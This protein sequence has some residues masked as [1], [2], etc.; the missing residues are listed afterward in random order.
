MY[1]FY[2]FRLGTGFSF[3]AGQGS[4]V[5]ALFK[6]NLKLKLSGDCGGVTA[7]VFWSGDDVE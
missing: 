4:F 3:F 1:R 5:K 2:C 6:S 7:T